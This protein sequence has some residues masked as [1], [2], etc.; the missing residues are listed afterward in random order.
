MPTGGGGGGGGL[1]TVSVTA[2]LT[3]NGT[4]GSPLD[5]AGWPGTFISSPFSQASGLQPSGSNDIAIFGF[6]LPYALTFANIAVFIQTADGSNNSDIGIYSQ[7]GSLVANIG[8]QHISSGNQVA[9]FATVQGSQTIVPGLYL[10]AMTSAAS[11]LTVYGGIAG[12]W[13]KNLNVASSTGG[14][15]ASSISAQTVSPDYEIPSF[16]LY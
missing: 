10:F 3:G 15:L 12:L 11:T 2:R 14:A 8:A 5:I 1:S 7:A 9:K 6:E 4:S 13:V 16:M